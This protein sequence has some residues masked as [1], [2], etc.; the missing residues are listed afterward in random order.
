M[1]FMYANG[2]GVPL[3]IGSALKW[4]EKAAKRKYAPAE[5]N[6]GLIYLNDLRH[7]NIGK[8]LSWV[9]LAAEHGFAE[10]ENQL[11]LLYE[12]GRG[13]AKDNNLAAKWFALAVKQGFPEARRNL[14]ALSA[15][16]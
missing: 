7:E 5:L 15:S 10:A 14:E 11:G 16:R 8:A 2:R 12:H 9:Q 4:Y 6:L 13:V 3:D 1:G